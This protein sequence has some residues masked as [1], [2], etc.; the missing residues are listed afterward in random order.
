M[1]ERTNTQLRHFEFEVSAERAADDAIPVV[2]SSDAVV[3]VSDGPEVLVHSREA[4]DLQRAPLPII[5]THR[6]GQVNVGIVDD[7]SIQGGR[8]RGMA[9]FGTRPEAAGYRDD[10]LN[11]I[12][13]SVSVGYA[14]VKSTLR[15]DGVLITTRWMPT[16]TA[17]VAEPA[18]VNAGFFRELPKFE[19]ETEPAPVAAVSTTPAAPSAIERSIAVSDQSNAAAGVNNAE[20][21]NTLPA[22]PRQGASAMDL[23]NGRKRT[24]ENLCRANKIDDGI[25]DHWIGT[26]AGTETVSKELLAILEQR[27]KSNPTVE[28]SRLGLTQKEAR[29]FSIFRAANAI[30]DKNWSN[31]GFELECTQAIAKRLGR[32]VPDPM[33]FFV[34]A[35]VQERQVAYVPGTTLQ[36]AS[37]RAAYGD[38]FKRDLTAAS[39]SGGGYTVGTMN[40]SYIEMLRGRAM[41]FAL[42]ATPLPGQRDN[43]T[44]PRQTATGSATWLANEASTISEVNQ[45]FGQ[46]SLSPKNVGAY[47]EISRQ[48]LLQSNPSIEGIVTS[49]LSIVTALAVDTAVL[50]GSG[51]G[52]QPTGIANTAGIGSVTGTSLA[53]DDILEFQTD[54]AGSNVR[55]VRGGYATTHAV[56]SLCIQRVKYSSTASPLWEGNVWDGTMQGFPAMASNQMAAG[57]MLFGDWSQVLVAE[58]GNLEIE[59]NPFAAFSAGIVGIRA[60]YSMDCGLRYAGAFSYASSIT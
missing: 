15:A 53:F 52:G 29:S 2:I 27:S 19:I 30:I 46:L 38:Y 48:L 13:R 6:G 32:D 18:D 35:E 51:S 34:P 21:V 31:A 3:D 14:R 24:I 5:A 20:N 37:A 42:G 56:A 45:T 47:T 59:V 39:A 44:I 22:Q 60:I 9:R 12:V 49:D 7:L 8:L 58:W 57:T 54:V 10:V 11:R 25:R 55:P 17:L 43:I 28:P 41:A 23:E 33:K 1:S 40:M 26:G 16:H 36:T 4:V 50:S